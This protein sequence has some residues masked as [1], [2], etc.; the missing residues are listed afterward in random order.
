MSLPLL[1]KRKIIISFIIWWL[2]LVLVEAYAT[3][4]SFGFSLKVALLDAVSINL[5]I[6]TAW[7]IIFNAFRYYRPS[8]SQAFYIVVW[9]LAEAVICEWIH[10]FLM[11]NVLP[12][13]TSYLDF[14]S[15]SHMVRGLI[16]WLMIMLVAIL[17][18]MW[19]FLRDLRDSE[20]REQDA[21][22]L[23]REAELARL[24]QQLQ[25]H[26]LFNSLNSISAL[27]GSQPEEARKMIQQLSDFLRGTVKRDDQQLISLQEELKHLELYLEIEKVRFGHRL[28]T[29][30]VKDDKSLNLK[31]PALLLQPVVENAIK[32]G[33]YDTIGE[34]VIRIEAKAEN[35]QLVLT[36]TN[37]FDP[38]TA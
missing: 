33:L 26:F 1:S 14:L 6:A 27:A 7:W 35:S 21:A 5:L 25:P 34:I 29:E 19:Y 17:S 37:P 20:Q 24:R 18:W 31:L 22:R 30:V 16:V 12:N 11:R 2:V 9:S 28:K 32:F 8:A 23:A 3:M 4:S 13:E 10:Y 36:V 38:S 15:H